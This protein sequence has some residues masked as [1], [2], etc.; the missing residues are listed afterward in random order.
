MPPGE[1]T[2][3]ALYNKEKLK[4]GGAQIPLDVHF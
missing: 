3:K 2:H 1:K 4:I